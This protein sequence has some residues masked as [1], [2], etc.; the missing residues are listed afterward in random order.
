MNQLFSSFSA[1]IIISVTNA[2]SQRVA[3]LSADESFFLSSVTNRIDDTL[4]EQ[5]SKNGSYVPR[6]QSEFLALSESR[7]V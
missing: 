7:S 4:S 2:L 6:T 3:H 1:K 5:R